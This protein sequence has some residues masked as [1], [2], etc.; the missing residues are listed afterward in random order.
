MPNL[1]KRP[2]GGTKGFQQTRVYAPTHRV[3]SSADGGRSV[4]GVSGLKGEPPTAN[5]RE[6]AAKPQ[7]PATGQASRRPSRPSGA[8]GGENGNGAEAAGHR[9]RVQSQGVNKTRLHPNTPTPKE[10]LTAQ[11]K[12]Q[13]SGKTQSQPGLL[14][15]TRRTQ[16]QAR[17][18]QSGFD[19]IHRLEHVDSNP[20]GGEARK[21]TEKRPKK[22]RGPL[23]R[24]KLM[25][26]LTVSVAV[27]GLLL[28]GY[29]VFLLDAVTVDG[30]D[31]YSD[32]NIVELS[33]L[34]TGTHLLLCDVDK[35]KAGIEANPYL[36]VLSIRKELPRAIRITVEERKEVAAI[37]GQGYDV[38]IDAQGHVLSIGAGSDLSG[39]LRVSGMSQIGFHVNQKLGANS[40]LQTQTLLSMLEQ[41][42]SFDLLKDVTE[43]DLSNPLNVCL[44]TRDGITVM[45]GQPD[46]IPGKLA[47]MR[48]V[49]PSLQAGGITEGTL[50]VSAK[51]GPIYSPASAGTVSPAP[52]QD[53]PDQENPDTVDPDDEASPG[54]DTE[55]VGDGAA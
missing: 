31:T 4:T 35:A 45:F 3:Q 18:K 48:D 30:N 14:N 51:G 47:W 25:A 24:K 11:A 55:P 26:R 22:K 32:E 27:L 46:D 53:V 16:E 29:F 8:A 2:P 54:S 37:A 1:H 7:R 9:Q 17:P 28:L 44:Y 21:N 34:H 20:T 33:G 43:L 40:D 52:E 49:M 39:L 12:A 41:L 36:K 42:I 19:S 15:K 13:L 38:I 6:S 5:R 50:D 10:I 23:N